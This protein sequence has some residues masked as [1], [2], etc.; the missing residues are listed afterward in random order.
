MAWNSVTVRFRSATTFSGAGRPGPVHIAAGSRM[1]VMIVIAVFLVASPAWGAGIFRDLT[2]QDR[3]HRVLL[4]QSGVSVSAA[5]LAHPRV[6]AAQGV[7]PAYLA[8]PLL[9]GEHLPA[10]VPTV[11]TGTP[12]T[13]DG[14]GPLELTSTSQSQLDADLIASHFAI[15]ETPGESYAVAFLPRYARTLAH[16]DSPSSS[17]S[18]ASSTTSTSSGSSSVFALPTSLS[19]WTIQGIPGSELSKWLQTGESEISHLTSLSVEK[20]GKSLGLSG[21]KATPTSS[22]LDLEAQYLVPPAGSS[23]ASDA[24][25]STGPLAVPAPE[26]AAWVAFGLIV[27]AAGF[28]RR[29]TGAGRGLNRRAVA[30]PARPQPPGRSL[31]KN[32]TSLAI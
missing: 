19:S 32:G 5:D 30:D 31:I 10:S 7:V 24:G 3:S 6:A 28:C 22:G 27:S 2:D 26:P 8:F 15:V 14:V 25:S 11:Q 18:T 21:L 13:P 9:G 12:S 20:V 16:S 17:T 23:A 1:P 29:A 4:S